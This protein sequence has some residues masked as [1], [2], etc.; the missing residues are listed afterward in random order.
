[1]LSTDNMKSPMH[2]T[3]R[4]PNWGVQFTHPDYIQWAMTNLDENWSTNWEQM[5]SHHVWAGN[6][7]L[8]RTLYILNCS[9][10][11]PTRSHS[12]WALQYNLSDPELEC[13]T[14]TS[15]PITIKTTNS[16]V[17]WGTMNAWKT[18]MIT[19]LHWRRLLTAEPLEVMYLDRDT[20]CKLGAVLT[21]PT[22][23][24]DATQHFICSRCLEHFLITSG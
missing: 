9:F 11:G 10:L 7:K 22:V 4:T 13:G 23:P 14:S 18:D 21:A 5:A 24:A 6:R 3:H 19:R 2:R 17:V 1:M 12:K 16:P 8:Q 20:S 15:V